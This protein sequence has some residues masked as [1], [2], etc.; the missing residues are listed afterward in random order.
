M[1]IKTWP[2]ALACV[3]VPLACLAVFAGTINLSWEPAETATGYKVGYGLASSTY[4]EIVNVGN[5]TT[6]AISR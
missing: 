2:I 4:T 5:T 6:A 3:L 1:K